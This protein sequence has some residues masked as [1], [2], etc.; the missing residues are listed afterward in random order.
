MSESVSALETFSPNL[1]VLLLRGSPSY[2]WSVRQSEILTPLASCQ[3]LGL[4]CLPNS[5][6][7]FPSDP[8][9]ELPPGILPTIKVYRLW[10]NSTPDQPKVSRK[11]GVFIV[12]LA[13][14][15]GSGKSTVAKHVASRL[16]GHVLSMETYAEMNHL[17]WRNEQS[18]PRASVNQTWISGTSCHRTLSALRLRTYC[19]TLG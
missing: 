11:Q 12:G 18:S 13:G 19:P 9:C 5:A 14:A 7:D 1:T 10:R 17:R 2:E 3:N 4:R 8:T 16:K 6:T 15:S